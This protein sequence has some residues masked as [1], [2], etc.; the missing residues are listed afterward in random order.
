MILFHHYP[1]IFLSFK[2]FF[3]FLGNYQKTLDDAAAAVNL[4]PLFIKAIERGQLL[5]TIF[6][7][8][9]IASL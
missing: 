2:F 5:A 7:D 1:F 6:I 3:F 4:Q 8:L 9:W